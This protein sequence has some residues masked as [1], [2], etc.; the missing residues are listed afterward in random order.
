[1]LAKT[2]VEVNQDLSCVIVVVIIFI[3]AFTQ[4]GIIRIAFATISEMLFKTILVTG[5][6]TY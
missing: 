1:M 4:T 5:I 3:I 6:I 2:L